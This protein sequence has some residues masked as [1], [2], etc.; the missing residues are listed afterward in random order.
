MI[1]LAAA[2]LLIAVVLH[3]WSEPLSNRLRPSVVVRAFSWIALAVALS[4]GLGLSVLA[5][6]VCVQIEP[7]PS[8]GQWSVRTLRSGSG[9]PWAVGFVALLVVVW[10]L[11]AACVQAARSARTLWAAAR[12]GSEF[13]PTS[14][15]L[16]IVEDSALFAYTVAALEGPIV[17]STAMLAALPPDERRVLL[18]HE[19]SHLRHR[20]Y[21][22][23][24]LSRL[25]AAANPLL[26]RTA[27]VVARGIEQW[28]D[29]DAAA[30][31]ED[32]A[33]AARALARA[34]LAGAGHPSRP[35]GLSVAD[36]GVTQRVQLLL[37]PPRPIRRV[38]TAAMIG[39]AAIGVIAAV[40]VMLWLRDLVEVAELA[41]F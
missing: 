22:Y 4:T 16:V 21:L 41:Y 25:A 37:A 7:L 13:T 5:V 2:P 23:L 6:L 32:R 11:I 17:V 29:E 36:G 8:I 30:A 15:D 24:H 35:H 26:V 3:V 10:W 12:L 9:V 34:G 18:A 31:V 33:L 1:A 38:Q 39:A 40:V 28:A 14:G 20:H 27:G 19:R